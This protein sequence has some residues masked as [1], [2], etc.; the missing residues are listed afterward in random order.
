MKSFLTVIRVVAALLVLAAMSATGMIAYHA[1]VKPLDGFPAKLIPQPSSHDDMKEAVE[2]A[3]SLEDRELP[4]YDPGIQSA[5][6]AQELLAMGQIDEAR[7]KLTRILVHYPNSSAADAARTILGEMN[8]DAWLGSQ[9]A[10]GRE[11]H[12]VK[13]GDSPLGI[14]GKYST[15]IDMMIHLNA[16][17]DFGNLQPGQQLVVMPLDFTLVI[18]PRRQTVSL[19]KEGTF[20][21]EYATL[22]MSGLS[23]R[24]QPTTI[25]RKIAEIEGR[26]VAAHTPEYRQAAKIL[27]LTNPPLQIRGWAPADPSE[28]PPGGIILR[29][30]DMEELGLLLRAGNAVEFR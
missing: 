28:E 18:E 29:P 13:R 7:S 27:Q 26:T 1:K 22:A 2:L 16:M 21:C 23:S 14:A 3:A 15:S 5:R 12:V 30:Y 10:P 25:A 8:L 17:M 20:V 24:P 4:D 9:H 11:V 6:Q 19:W